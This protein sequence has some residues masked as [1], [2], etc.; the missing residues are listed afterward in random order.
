M[1][2]EKFVVF[3]QNHDQV[4]NRMRGERLAALVPF[5]GAQAGGRG[6]SC[7]PYVPLLFMGEE[8]GEESPFLYF[9]DHWDPELAAG[10]ARREERGIQGVRMGGRACPTPGAS[11][12]SRRRRSTWEKR[13]TGQGKDTCATTSAASCSVRRESRASPRRTRDRM[14]VYA[15]EADK[16]RRGARWDEAGYGLLAGSTLTGRQEPLTIP[17]P[18]GR[19]KKVLDSG[20]AVVGRRPAGPAR[21]P[22]GPA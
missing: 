17:L 6:A 12:P 2:A 9:V 11:R 7:S 13:H 14:E 3:C 19:W 8:Y 16:A 21:G 4:G 20:D 22:P 5:R 1:P 15:S 10:R 18:R